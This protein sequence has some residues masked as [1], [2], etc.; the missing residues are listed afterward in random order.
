MKT[1]LVAQLLRSN[2]EE[3]EANESEAFVADTSPRA[4]ERAARAQKPKFSL[5]MWR[6]DRHVGCESIEGIAD[7]G[8]GLEKFLAIGMLRAKRGISRRRMTKLQQETAPS[9][10][11]DLSASTPEVAL[12]YWRLCRAGSA[13]GFAPTIDE[14]R[15]SLTAFGRPLG[16]AVEQFIIAADQRLLVGPS[17]LAQSIRDRDHGAS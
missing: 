1:C 8:A 6:T 11:P 13:Q 17:A 4:F 3:E 2:F 7:F 10:R 14:S 5:V 15:P 16:T 12:R 9:E